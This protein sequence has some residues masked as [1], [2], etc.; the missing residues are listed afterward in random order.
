MVEHLGCFQSFA[1]TKRATVNGVMPTSFHVFASLFLI[2]FLE[3]GL[4][5]Q[6]VNEC[7]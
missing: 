3:V 6:W 7:M 1:I 4:V 2:G 5:G